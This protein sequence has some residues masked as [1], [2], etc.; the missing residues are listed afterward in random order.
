M[1]TYNIRQQSPS[2]QVFNI[3]LDGGEYSLTIYWLMG[4]QR[5]YFMIRDNSGNYILNMPLISSNYTEN[6]IAGYFTSS[7]MYYNKKDELV[8]ILP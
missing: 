7:T 3:V 6:L 5:Y 1:S 2:P 8:E 4:A